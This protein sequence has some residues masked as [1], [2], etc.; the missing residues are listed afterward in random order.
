MDYRDLGDLEIERIKSENFQP[1]PE[2]CSRISDPRQLVAGIS[3]ALP[4]RS[5]PLIAI[6]DDVLGIRRVERY[7][8]LVSIRQ[9]RVACEIIKFPMPNRRQRGGKGFTSEDEC[10]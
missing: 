9:I 4:S 6:S 2:N 8:N 3:L 7:I 5:N 10:P 1:S